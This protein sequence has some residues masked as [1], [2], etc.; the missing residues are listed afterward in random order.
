MLDKRVYISFL[1]DYFYITGSIGRYKYKKKIMKVLMDIS[2]H[3]PTIFESSGAIKMPSETLN[4]ENSLHD[5]DLIYIDEDNTKL[6]K[7]IQ[8]NKNIEIIQVKKDLLM[9]YYKP[10]RLRIDIF[11]CKKEYFYTYYLFTLLGKKINIILRKKAMSYNLILNQY[12]LFDRKTRNN[13]KINFNYKKDLFYNLGMILK[14]I[15][16]YK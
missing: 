3:L 13:I 8:E 10:K 4:Y 14:K 7:K 12:G 15:Y 1:N 5:I 11:I 9:L 16:S 6:L 2:E